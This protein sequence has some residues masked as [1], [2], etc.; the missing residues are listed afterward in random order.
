[1]LLL[2]KDAANATGSVIG[3]FGV[4]WGRETE[5]LF[6]NNDYE[7]TKFLNIWDLSSRNSKKTYLYLQISCQV[8]AA[9]EF[10]E[11]LIYEADDIASVLRYL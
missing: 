11:T 3:R 10:V 6:T 8:R 5:S 9:I 2:G 4:T 7:W 1:M